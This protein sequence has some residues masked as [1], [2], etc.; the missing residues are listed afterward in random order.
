MPFLTPD[1]KAPFKDILGLHT[2]S[3][4]SLIGPEIPGTAFQPVLPICLLGLSVL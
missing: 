2:S 3:C 1:E 4:G